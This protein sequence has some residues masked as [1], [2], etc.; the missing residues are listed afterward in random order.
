M[1]FSIA[2]DLL[3]KYPSTHVGLIF[4]KGCDN[5]TVSPEVSY[6]LRESEEKLRERMSDKA[7][8]D[9]PELKEWRETYK[10]FG[11]KKGR[12]V[13]IEAMAKRVNKGDELPSISPLVDLY[14]AV[15]LRYIFPCGGEDLAHVHG[16]VMLGFAEGNEAFLRIGGEENEP[17]VPG[18][19]VYKDD[20]GCL[21]R[22][23]NWREADRT[24]LTENTKDAVL[25]IETLDPDRNKEFV[26][27]M[28]HMEDLVK[29]LTGAQTEMYVLNKKSPEIEYALEV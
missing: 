22:S 9:L 20:E 15:S 11:A 6:I 17:P 24:K 28:S 25:V 3:E 19:V 1:K 4:V 10:S 27:A 5:K 29:A 18:E 13:S 7:L 2:S 12:R 8:L 16:D 23:W 26:D 14:N 21:C